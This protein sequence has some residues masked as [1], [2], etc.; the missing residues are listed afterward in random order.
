[1]QNIIHADISRKES[2]AMA[3]FKLTE[4][5]RKAFRK[6][7]KRGVYKELYTQKLIT[8]MQLNQLLNEHR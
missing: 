6:A 5:E 7:L 8:D 2:A 1:M 3:A 4:N